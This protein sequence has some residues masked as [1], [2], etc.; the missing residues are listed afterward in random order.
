LLLASLTSLSSSA[1]GGQRFFAYI[2]DSYYAAKSLDQL[3]DLL[4]PVRYNPAHNFRVQ[5]LFHKILTILNLLKLVEVQGFEPC[6]SPCKSDMLPL[7][8]YP[9]GSILGLAI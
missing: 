4:S 1:A 3:C 7:S 6:L 8:L 5:G 2:Q 9:Q